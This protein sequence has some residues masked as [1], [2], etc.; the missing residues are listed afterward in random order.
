MLKK[1]NNCTFC[2]S[3]KLIKS[4]KQVYLENYY[5]KSIITDLNLSKNFLKKIKIYQC[6]NCFILQN[7]PWFSENFVRKIYSNIYGQHHRNWENLLNF[8]NKKQTPNH[9][10]LFE[11]LTKTIQIKNYAEFNSP[12]M[13]LMLNFFE[14]VYRKEKSFFK[15]FSDNV[16]NYLN[17]RQLAGKSRFEKN[18]S[19]KKSKKYLDRIKKFKKKIKPVL[20]NK[21]LFVD[22]SPLFW[23]Q[24]DNYKSVNS[25]SYASEL[26]D[27]EVH[28]LSYLKDIKKKLDLFGIFHTLDHTF[29]PNKVLNYALNASNYVIVYCHIDQ[30]LNKQHLFSFTR[31]FLDFLKR[32]R[33][34]TIE[35]TNLINK[36][37]NS[38]ELYFLCSRKKEK[39]LKFKNNAY[40]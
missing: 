26:L 14:K 5:I 3:K 17:S 38:P 37:L 19:K 11:L 7:N 18:I 1:Y 2:N 36:K 34:Y 16:I 28:A 22:N 23:G 32:K 21:Y 30:K 12:F 4:N 6:K 27:L 31:K 10:N 20:K 13:G 35:L 39:I 40:K 9:G 15:Y 8:V 33:I 29:E 25:R 24:N